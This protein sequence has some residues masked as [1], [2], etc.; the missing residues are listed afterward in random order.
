MHESI[1]N[2]LYQGERR[3]L[4]PRFDAARA[5]LWRQKHAY[6]RGPWLKHSLEAIY[7]IPLFVPVRQYRQGEGKRLVAYVIGFLHPDG[8]G[9]NSWHAYYFGLE[10]KTCT[11]AHD[12]LPVQVPHHAVQ[13]LMQRANIDKPAVALSWLRPALE[14]VLLLHPAPSREGILL[15]GLAG[16]VVARQDQDNSDGWVFVTF[17]DD[18]KLRPEQQAEVA[19]RRDAM[20][21]EQYWLNAGPPV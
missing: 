7:T 14:Y 6:G 9:L 13:R 11:V 2:A 19:G 12:P 17:I 10:V 3:T 21:R 15:P 18:D 8:V 4:Q 20:A 16:A 5:R 1:A